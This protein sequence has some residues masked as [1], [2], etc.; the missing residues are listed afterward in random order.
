[1]AGAMKGE[2]PHLTKLAP[3]WSLDEAAHHS[4]DF[5][6]TTE[7][8]PKPDNRVTVDNDGNIHVDYHNTN[9]S[10]AASLYGEFRK[11]L[12]HVGLAKHH[13]LHKNFYMGMNLPIAAVAHQAGTARFGTDPATSVLDINCK[14]HE[15][16]NLYVT[17][18]SFMPSLGA[19]NPALTAIANAIRVGEQIADRLG[20][21]TA[22]GASAAPHG[23]TAATQPRR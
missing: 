3:R 22:A 11:M 15:V 18:T 13:V 4:V 12:N 2:E 6:L 8:L 14:A 19:V 10:E 16:D 1:N 17:D 21:S 9:E 23:A 7:D 5:W 20:V